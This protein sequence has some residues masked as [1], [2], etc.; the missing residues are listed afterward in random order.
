MNR[1]FG[2]ENKIITD[3][4]FSIVGKITK[5]YH[6]ECQSS[7][8]NSMLVRIF[9]YG[10]QI[11]LDEG[12]ILKNTLTVKFPH[13]AILFLRHTKNTPDKMTVRII[14]PGGEASYD[15]PVIKIQN[16]DVKKIFDKNL[17]LFLPFHIFSYEKKFV[18]YENIPEEFQKLLKEYITVRKNLENLQEEGNIREYTK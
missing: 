17:L 5:K 14:T 10:T 1:Y 6:L 7:A 4:S 13:S 8:D 18:N 9:E 11:A 16:Y 15:V 2:N 12:E 3:T